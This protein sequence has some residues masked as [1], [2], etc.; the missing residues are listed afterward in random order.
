M[1]MK[2]TFLDADGVPLAYK[3]TKQPD[4]YMALAKLP[5]HVDDLTDSDCADEWIMKWKYLT[6]EICR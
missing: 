6:I 3:I 5:K 4:L 2:I 1:N